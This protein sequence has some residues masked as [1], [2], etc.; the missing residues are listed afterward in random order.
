MRERELL[1]A[2]VGLSDGA[3][4]VA[5]RTAS[6]TAILSRR[7]GAEA[8]FDA[9][10]RAPAAGARRAYGPRERRCAGLAARRRAAR[11]SAGCRHR[12]SRPRTGRAVLMPRPGGPGGRLLLGAGRPSDRPGSPAPSGPP[13]QTGQ[14]RAERPSPTD[15]AVPRR[16]ALPDRPGSPAPSGPPR[17]TGQSRAG[18]PSPTDR[19]VPRQAALP[20]RPG[21]PAPSGPPRQT[22]QSRARR[23][24]RQAGW[25]CAGR[26]SDRPWSSRRAVVFPTRPVLGRAAHGSTGR[27][28]GPAPGHADGP[29]PGRGGGART[30]RRRLPRRAAARGGARTGG[31]GAAPGRAGPA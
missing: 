21:S 22:G 26:P 18:Q 12:P 14:S 7:P 4:S 17:Q 25:S 9:L 5:R 15:R 27:A 24:F 10:F 3:G 11:A 30:G 31:A 16:A 20:D 1:R 23:P 29:A 6:R 8:V 19:A 28:D 13:R 2:A